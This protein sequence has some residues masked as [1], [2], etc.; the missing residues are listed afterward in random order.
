MKPVYLRTIRERKKLTQTQL[1]EKA[2]VLQKTISKLETD[3]ETK[4]AF[5][6]VAKLADALGVDPR[7][8]RF[9]PDPACGGEAVAS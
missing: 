9:G 8:L 3:S 5:D 2:G 7:A 1:G 4:P 6:T